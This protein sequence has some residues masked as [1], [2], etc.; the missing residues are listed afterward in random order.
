MIKRKEKKKK[1]KK[2]SD[3]EL[4]WN[5]L[6]MAERKVQLSETSVE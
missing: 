5:R 2:I 6:Q 1:R 3:S 4:Q